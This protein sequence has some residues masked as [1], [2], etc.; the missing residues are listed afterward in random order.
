MGSLCFEK[1]IIILWNSW[2]ITVFYSLKFIQKVKQWHNHFWI[3]L[4][5]WYMNAFH[6]LCVF[7]VP[8]SFD[9]LLRSA[10]NNPDNVGRYLNS[11]SER[12]GAQIYILWELER[13]TVLSSTV[14]E[15]LHALSEQ[16]L[17]WT[18]LHLSSLF[19]SW[20]QINVFLPYQN[21]KIFTP[22]ERKR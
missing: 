2:L 13:K 20:V 12:W 4:L 3:L 6:S 18:G 21:T 10:A 5:F 11:L 22:K 8:K 9:M 17:L 14:D 7:L 19:L 16:H 15:R 1:D